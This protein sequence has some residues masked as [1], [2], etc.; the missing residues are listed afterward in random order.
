M[1]LMLLTLAIV[2]SLYGHAR[3][4]SRDAA[5]KK[6]TPC[7]TT[8]SKCG[9]VITKKATYTVAAD[10]SSTDG[11]T[12]DGDCIEIQVSNV[13]LNLGTHKVAGPGGANV[14][15]GIDVKHGSN[16]D[17]LLG[18]AVAPADVTEWGTGV[19]VAGNNEIVSNVHADSNDSF[20]FELDGSSN[21]RFTDWEASNPEGTYGLW[22]RNGSDNFI[23]KGNA[24][25][26]GDSGIFVGCADIAS[27]AG[28]DCKRVTK[29]VSNDLIDNTADSN[30]NYGIGLDLN[31]SQTLVNADSG[32]GN[33]V[34]DLFDDSPSCGSN[35]W[36]DDSGT[37]SDTCIE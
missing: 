27:T 34:H 35:T 32:S 8:I 3:A 6:P 1:L 29:S 17:T 13:I 21:D 16:N 22:I 5:R 31:D 28:E 12:P 18:D 19:Y 30:K 24:S 33:G 10:L 26:N 15:V 37:A 25:G 11:L 36:L 9:C 7:S 2:A 4:Q 23:T 14:D 20:G